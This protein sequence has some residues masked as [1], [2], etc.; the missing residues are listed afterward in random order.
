MY[1][2]YFYGEQFPV[3]LYTNKKGYYNTDDYIS[4]DGET[5]KPTNKQTTKTIVN[6]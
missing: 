4:K 1:V 3:Y 5:N 2:T 6:K